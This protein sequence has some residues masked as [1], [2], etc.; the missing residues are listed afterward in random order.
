MNDAPGVTLRGRLICRSEAEAE[1]VRRFLPDHITQSRAEPGC[2][3]F[4]VFQKDDPL[5]WLVEEH[6]RD[7]A[8]FKAHQTRTA[9]SDWGRATAHLSRDYRQITG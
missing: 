9:A 8:A 5:V 6:F 3:E 7:Q 2:L 1:I 4:R